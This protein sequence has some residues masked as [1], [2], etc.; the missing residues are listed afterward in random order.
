[1]ERAPTIHIKTDP[2]ITSYRTRII[3]WLKKH[4]VF[5]FTLIV[6]SILTFSLYLSSRPSQKFDPAYFNPSLFHPAHQDKLRAAPSVDYL[7]PDNF[8]SW[9]H[10]S[11]TSTKVKAAFVVIAR[12]EE[13][14]KLHTTIMDIQRH[15]NHDYPWIIIGHK[16]F[17]T[18]FR[19][20]ITRIATSPVSFGLA[21]TIEW[22]EPYWINIRRAEQ[23]LKQMTKLGLPKGE[24]M[25]WRRMTRYNAGFVAFHPLLKDLEFYW[26]VQPGAR[27][28]CD[29]PIDPFQRM[30]DE[31]KK[32]SFALTKTENHEYIQSFEPVVKA[33]IRRNKRLIQPVQNSVYNALLDGEEFEPNELGDYGGHYS[34][35]MIYNNF[36]II[37]LDFLRSKEYNM[38]F[39]ALD[40]SGG[41]FYEKWGDAFPQTM[42]AAL[43]L[44]R[45]QISFDDIAGYHYDEGAV[46]PMDI[47]QYVQLKCT[48]DPFSAAGIYRNNRAVR[49]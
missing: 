49:I 24:S 44:T 7:Y 12:E 8:L 34:N 37:S 36:M 47:D 40:S 5:S 30:K 45:Q 23:G 22:Q 11:N 33:F 48:C 42:A 17:S 4:T 2:T 38:F 28:H 20:W 46:C 35:C 43:F 15:F 25:H 26:K 3:Y 31:K 29:I 41:F 27:Y 16:V 18:H 10:I 6:A 13:L 32:L 9:D 1:G 14:Y 21:P 39:D 19:N